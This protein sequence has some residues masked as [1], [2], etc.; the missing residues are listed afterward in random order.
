MAFILKDRVRE[1]T[2]TT[3]T[4]TFTLAGAVAGHRAFSAVLSN[5]DTTWYACVL[6]GGAW[7]V[8]LGTWVTGNQLQRTALLDSSTGSA[9]S[10]AAGT[11][12][13]FIALPA[14]KGNPQNNSF[15]PGTLLLFQQTAAPTYWTK[16]VTHN[17]KVL[18]VVSGTASSGGTNAFSTVMAQTVVGNTTID[19]TTQGVHAHGS[20]APANSS[21]GGIPG[22]GAFPVNQTGTGAT[23]N[24]STG[25][26][27]HNHTITLAIQ[28]V[29]L[30]IASKDA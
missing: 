8:G 2:T 30:I 24:N 15:V 22:G 11:K 27:A 25:G 13:V 26:T 19:S 4:G 14:S 9:I 6:P 17:D 28:Y 1:T 10:F 16:Q 21:G 23:I 20:N 5:L 7:E 29:D 3:G 12:D 18:R